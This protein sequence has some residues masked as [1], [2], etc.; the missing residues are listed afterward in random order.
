[1]VNTIM[2]I[3]LKTSLTILRYSEKEY[4]KRALSLSIY[5][6]YYSFF[7]SRGNVVKMGQWIKLRDTNHYFFSTMFFEALIL[8]AL[9]VL[10]C[11]YRASTEKSRVER[12]SREL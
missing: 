8:P 2:Y 6:Y 11:M 12:T 1:M 4:F 10:C 5:S 7:F 3:F 9:Y